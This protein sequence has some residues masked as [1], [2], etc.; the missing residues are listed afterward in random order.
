M[1]FATASPSLVPPGLDGTPADILDRETQ[2][3]KRQIEELYEQV[4][5]DLGGALKRLT[6]SYEADSDLRA[7]LLQ[8]ICLAIW[9]AL[10]RF[11]RQ[12]SLKTFV[13][14]IAHNR[15]L[16]WGWRASRQPRNL[17]TGDEP[18]ALADRSLSVDDR[19][20]RRRRRRDL[21]SAILELPITWRQVVTL[22]L[23]DLSYREIAEILGVTENNVM[24]RANRARNRLRE[25]LVADKE[26]K[27]DNR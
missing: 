24:V 15:G 21:E 17:T 6:A 7:D 2:P 13:F 1:T 3:R 4:L 9:Q 8:E 18:E 14:R 11:R 22:R 12:S 10:P 5:A 20:D 16:T 25:L 23:E 26:S 27:D 19:L